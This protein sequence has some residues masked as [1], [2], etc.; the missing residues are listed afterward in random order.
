MAS[1]RG[2]AD[3]AGVRGDGWLSSDETARVLGVTVRTVY[4][5]VDA[6]RLPAYRFGRVIRFRR[7]EVDAF[8][9]SSRIGVR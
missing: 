7:H 1:D 2:D 5:L 8:I 4:R 9:E 3:H 6:G